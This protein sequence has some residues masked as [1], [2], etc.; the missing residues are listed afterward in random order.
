M[1]LG[2]MVRE[3]SSLRSRLH[4]DTRWLRASWINEGFSDQEF[5]F[6]F[7]LVLF[8]EGRHTLFRGIA[9]PYVFQ[10]MV[11]QWHSTGRD[12][13]LVGFGGGDN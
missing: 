5:P 12:L 10:Q 9:L 11:Q 7:A 6:D 13:Y 3:R 8:H 1:N 4:S 2:A